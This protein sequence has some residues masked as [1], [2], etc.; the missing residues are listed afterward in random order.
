M[1]DVTNATNV[2]YGPNEREHFIQ[3]SENWRLFFSRCQFDDDKNIIIAQ[4]NIFHSLVQFKRSRV[5]KIPLCDR[6]FSC[7]NSIQYSETIN[8]IWSSNLFDIC[9]VMLLKNGFLKIFKPA[10]EMRHIL[11]IYVSLGKYI[12]QHRCYCGHK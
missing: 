6:C 11:L 3:S 10:F 5:G 9:E 12:Q 8:R 7:P 4:H 1:V 2:S